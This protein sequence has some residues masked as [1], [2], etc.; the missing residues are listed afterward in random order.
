MMMLN[1]DSEK[2]YERIY[3]CPFCKEPGEDKKRKPQTRFREDN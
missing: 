3:I 2:K 1:I